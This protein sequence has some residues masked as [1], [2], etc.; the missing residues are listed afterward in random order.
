VPHHPLWD[1]LHR[2]V[3]LV[4]ILVILTRPLSKHN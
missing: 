4:V 1:V 2:L 3:S